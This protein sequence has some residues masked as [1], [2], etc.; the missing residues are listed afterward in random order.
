M[1]Y[2]LY[3][4]ANVPM[5][6]HV[7]SRNTRAHSIKTRH[8]ITCMHACAYVS[9]CKC[10]CVEFIS[11]LIKLWRAVSVGRQQTEYA[12]NRL[13]IEREIRELE[14]STEGERYEKEE[15]GGDE[16]G[17]VMSAQPHF[18]SLLDETWE[19]PPPCHTCSSQT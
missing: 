5:H 18:N 11:R 1:L 15:E 4:C 2:A 8:K 9:V 14:E 6:K 7:L 19:R 13:L 17:I 12:V 3:T 16:R 10:V